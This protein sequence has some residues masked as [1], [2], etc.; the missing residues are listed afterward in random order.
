MLKQIKILGLALV[1]GSM[2][3]GCDSEISDIELNDTNTIN[4]EQV[5][6]NNKIDGISFDLKTMS[7][8]MGAMVEYDYLTKKDI[9]TIKDH[10][11]EFID[12][13]K[14]GAEMIT[15][16]GVD[17]P[18]NT[19]AMDLAES[20]KDEFENEHAFWYLYIIYEISLVE[21]NSNPEVINVCRH[22]NCDK[23]FITDKYTN[24]LYLYPSGECGCEYDKGVYLKEHKITAEEAYSVLN[25]DYGYK[26]LEIIKQ[27]DTELV[28][29]CGESTLFVVN[30]ETRI[31]DN[32]IYS[33]KE[34]VEKVILKAYNPNWV[35]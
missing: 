11:P 14:K 5:D 31:I 32:H 34:D 35:R 21:N 12:L 19:E 3:V 13:G 10:A 15:D 24:L 6:E 22:H 26:G 9:K 2:L 17:F 16:N 27:D 30:L 29:L 8:Y 18:N 33:C 28:V 20:Y 4:Q 23:Q 7:K 25:N 1:I